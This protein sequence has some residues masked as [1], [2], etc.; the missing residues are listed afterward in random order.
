[1]ILLGRQGDEKVS[2]L[3]EEHRLSM[4]K[5]CERLHFLFGLIRFYLLPVDLFSRAQ[6]SH[7][8]QGV[9]A[10]VAQRIEQRFPKPLAGSSTLPGGTDLFASLRER[11]FDPLSLK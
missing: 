7:R 3:W 8:T 4:K 5:E 11:A 1:M 6:P 9:L 10:P 2:G